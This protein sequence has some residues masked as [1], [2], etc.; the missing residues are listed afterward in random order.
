[1]IAWRIYFVSD[2]FQ[3]N[4]EN[5]SSINYVTG[6]TTLTND[7]RF[8]QRSDAIFFFG[9]G[10]TL[11]NMTFADL[12]QVLR[13]SFQVYWTED[14][15]GDLRL[16]HYSFFENV[17]VGLDV[18]TGDQA[19]Y[20]KNK[21]DYDYKKELLPFVEN[22]FDDGNHHNYN[23]DLRE[24]K[25]VDN[26]GSKLPCVGVN[27]LDR[28]WGDI[29]SDFEYFFEYPTDIPRSGWV[30]VACR[31]YLG[32]NEIIFEDGLLNGTLSIKRLVE[33]YY[34]NGRSALIGQV[35]GNNTTFESTVRLKTQEG[36]SFPICCDDDFDPRDN[37]KTPIGIGRVIT[38]EQDLK[39]KKL[40][41]NNEY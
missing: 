14:I 3:I 11:G 34:L 15:N 40:T 31:L 8:I 29:N 5:P 30:M 35:N 22:V 9:Q 38:A 1:M 12:D 33:R 37:I 24:I 16:E 4:P 18:T 41:T 21:T 26:N 17:S 32:V 6:A 7:I 39:T 13:N 25:Y 28:S 2:F 10:A 27:D 20:T 19:I 23:W 36:L